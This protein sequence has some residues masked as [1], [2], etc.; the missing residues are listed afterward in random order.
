MCDESQVLRTNRVKTGIKENA[1]T[2]IYRMCKEK[3]KSVCHMLVVFISLRQK[4]NEDKF[5]SESKTQENIL[6]QR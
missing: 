4:D 1:E 2:S 3:D 6:R 5:D